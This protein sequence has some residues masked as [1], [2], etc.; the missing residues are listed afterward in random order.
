MRYRLFGIILETEFAFAT[1]LATGTGEPDLVFAL[2][3]E[4]P[5]TEWRNSPPLYESLHTLPDGRRGTY[6]YRHGSCDVLRFT[7]I[8]HFY[9]WPDRIACQLLDP[10]FDYGVEIFFLGAVM[11]LWLERRGVLALHASAAVVDGGAV[12]FLASNEGGKTTLAAGMMQRGHALHSDDVVAVTQPGG[13]ATAHAGYPQMR[14]W[15]DQARRFVADTIRL[16]PVHPRIEKLRV[17]LGRAGLGRFCGAPKPLRCIYLPERTGRG[18]IEFDTVPPGEAVFRIIQ[19]SFVAELASAARLEA[20]RLGRV[21][22]LVE[23]VPVTRM[24]YPSGVDALPAVCEA[25]R[26]DL[27]DRP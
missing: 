21:A 20:A 2:V 22:A 14:M 25:I 10:A 16:D 27:R 17:P 24:T 11:A 3:P 7:G 1:P 18:E 19:Q 5:F 12:A 9:L 26:A 23:T 4:A 15:P 6:L 8:A 13:A